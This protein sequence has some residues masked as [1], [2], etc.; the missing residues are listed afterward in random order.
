[1]VALTGIVSI[2]AGDSHSLALRADGTTWAWGDGFYGQ[3]GDGTT[4]DR[5]LPNQVP[6]LTGG[7]A[8]AAGGQ[9][10]LLTKGDGTTWSWGGNSNGQLGIGSTTASLV[11]VQISGLQDVVSIAAGMWH[12]LARRADG[13]LVAWGRNDNR[14]LGDGTTTQRTSPVAVSV[15]SAVTAGPS[16]GQYHGLAAATDNVAWGWGSG[17]YGGLCG[18]APTGPASIPGLAVNAV[19]AGGS[20][21]I[22]RLL[23]GTLRACGYNA[24]GS[25]GAGSTANESA[26]PLAVVGLTGVE[27]LAAG[28]SHALAVTPGGVVWAWGLNSY[29]QVGDGT[30][31][32]RNTPVK[33]TEAGFQ[34]KVAT[35]VI[36]SATGTYYAAINVA[37]SSSTP[38]ATIRYTTNGVEPTEADSLVTGGTVA[39]SQSATLKVK[40][41]KPGLA[42]SNTETAVYT[43]MVQTL[44]LSPGWGTY[45]TA[46]SVVVSCPIAGTTARYTTNGQDPTESDPTI[47]CG[48][49]IP[50]DQTLTLKVKGWKSGWS[51]SS[52]TAAAYTM[53]VGTPTLLPSGGE[54]TSTQTVTVTTVTPGATLNFTT[55]GREPLPTDAVV[56][57]GASIV[58]N[59]SQSLKV[60]GRRAGWSNSATAAGMYYLVAGTTPAPTLIPPAGSY[61]AVQQVHLLSATPDA[62]VR[63]TLDGSEPGP[64]SPIYGEPLTLDADATIKARAFGVDLL[65]SAV[66]TGAYV[67]ANTAAVV[68]PNFTPPAGR[69]ATQQSVAIA[70]PTAGSTVR[71]S[72]DGDDPTPLDPELTSGQT[73]VVDRSLILKAKAWKTG[74]TE[75][76]VR[77]GFY[78]VTGDLAA[79]D[80]HLL[81]LASDGRVRGWGGNSYG[82]LGDGTTTVRST[83]TLIPGLTNVV[84][85]AAGESHSLALKNDGSV[86]AWGLNA[87]GQLGNGTYT[88]SLV[89]QA[90]PGLSGVVRISAGQRHS[91]AVKADGSAWA[92][93]DNS[94]GQLGDGSTTQRTSPVQLSGLPP[95]V[96]IDGGMYHSLALTVDG[97]VY[98]CGRNYEGQLGDGTSVDRHSPVRVFGLTGVSQI[99]A[100]G[101]FSVALKTDGGQAGQVWA[102]GQN[103]AGQLGNSNSANSSLPVVAFEGA[104]T[105]SA[106]NNHVLALSLEGTLWAW[107]DGSGLFGR[108]GDG[109]RVWR[110]GP[111]RV[112]SLR[113]GVVVAAGS[114]Y[115]AVIRAGGG[116]EIWGYNLLGTNTDTP[117]PVPS[118]TLAAN[119]WLSQDSD[120]DGLTAWDE[121][122][123]GTDPLA[124]DTNADGIPDGL[125]VGLGLSASNFDRDGDGLLNTQE[126]S[127]GT[128]LDRADSD[129][130]GVSDA[131][132]CLP[133]DATL[134]TC[135]IDPEDHTP[136]TITLLE[137]PNGILLP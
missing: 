81:T 71:Y 46:Q 36:G 48:G 72:T 28:E 130:D 123:Y 87:H 50:V 22:L 7:V 8:I 47:A 61:P 135:T 19:A 77:Q 38:G 27:T 39:I 23:D 42:D 20:F 106:G 6:G 63:Y 93:G 49:A 10:S 57:S 44:G 75:S 99:S 113:D 53:V 43:L 90:V 11:P 82:Q 2:A 111:V 64:S 24:Y 69:F 14:Q 35:P 45:N 118:L 29:G 83:P 101:L 55:D 34:F 88:G 18:L 85:V 54:Y 91:L 119:A 79:G 124:P 97:K 68:A 66:T 5:L 41:F 105:I 126:L 98:G 132:D 60:I 104:T 137:P 86:W 21:S 59:R 134:A 12:S 94:N 122:R 62:V 37:V 100:G 70:S 131:V 96:A 51:P 121:W 116:V 133:L 13:S 30:T 136:P 58:V 16:A 120:D 1:M 107:G 103:A 129:G 108:L 84:A 127:L 4:T 56:A 125:A 74:L 128:D 25:L 73:V 117:S 67:I 89:P 32:N 31:V 95:V 40:A 114:Y 109:A 65:P 3:L 17:S 15:A 80:T 115:S 92:W 52:V 78:L 33:I 26:V 9:H 76:P 112:P 102:W 110:K